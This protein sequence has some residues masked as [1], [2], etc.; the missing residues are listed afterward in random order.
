MA[1]VDKEQSSELKETAEQTPNDCEQDDYADDAL[2]AGFL[3][4]GVADQLKKSP[5]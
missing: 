1:E 4:E 3:P 5:S 2:K